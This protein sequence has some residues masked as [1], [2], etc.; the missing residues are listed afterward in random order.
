MLYNI[1][2]VSCVA[3]GIASEY[4]VGPEFNVTQRFYVHRTLPHLIVVEVD[5]VRSNTGNS[6]TLKIDL[7]RWTTSYDLTIHKGETNK[8]E[9]R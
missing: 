2:C 1:K 5:L 9:V 3:T 4:I 8:H 6:V 7:N